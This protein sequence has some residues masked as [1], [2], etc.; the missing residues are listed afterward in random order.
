MEMLAFRPEITRDCLLT[1]GRLQGTVEDD[2]RDEQ[3]GKIL[4]EA[5]SGELARTG[6][7]AFGR[8]Y[9]SIDSTPLF[10]QTAAEYWY[11]TGDVELVRRLWPHLLACWE[12]VRRYGDRDGD[13]YVEYERRSDNGLLNQG[14][15]DSWSAV[16]HRDGSLAS[17]PVALVEVQAYLYA[18]LTGMA[19]IGEAVGEREVVRRLRDEA[20]VLRARFNRDFWMPGQRYYALALDGQKRQVQSITSNPS[21]ALFAGI[22]PPRRAS[23]LARHLMSAPLFGGWGVRTLS[24]AS[25]RFNPTGYH[26]GSVWP[27]DNALVAAGLKRYGQDS[28]L[29]ALATALYDCAGTMDYYRLPELF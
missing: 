7:V 5:R 13:G 8:Y 25:P 16:V 22:V 2:W 12:W 26:I 20:K 9:G 14:R 15:K 21:H 17:Y 11:W 23:A 24:D 28:A 27:H 10:M 3:P 18:G 4:H 6:E 19:S 1:L 29:L